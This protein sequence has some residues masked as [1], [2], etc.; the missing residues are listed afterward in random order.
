[1]TILRICLLALCLAYLAQ[2]ATPLR[3]DTDAE[4]LLD[5]AASAADGHGFLHHGTRGHLPL[6][7]PAAIMILDRAGLGAAW[8]FVA[9]NVACVALALACARD[10]YRR[11]FDLP[12][13]QA[14][15]LC[16]LSLLSFPLVK[17]VTLSTSDVPYLGLSMLTLWLLVRAGS[18]SRN[19]RW[20]L[21]AAALAVAAAAI[22]TRTIGI[23]LLLPIAA[24]LVHQK[25]SGR[26]LGLFVSRHRW[27]VGSLALGGMVAAAVI[28]PSAVRIR[29]EIAFAQYAEAGFLPTI[30]NI[31]SHRLTEWGSLA[32]NLPASR[33][34][35]AATFFLPVLGLAVLIVLARGIWLRREKAGVLE[36][37]L[38]AYCAL[39]CLWPSSMNARFWVPM[40][41]L[42]AAWA[43]LALRG[44][45]ASLWWRGLRA[46]YVAGFAT[47]GL[48]A[49]AFST[50]LSFSGAKFSERYGDTTYRNS[51]RAAF[52]REIEP[53]DPPADPAAIRLLQR[54]EPLARTTAAPPRAE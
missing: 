13:V 34:P 35:Q 5:L 28:F 42:L 1:M 49:L 3:L 53:V 44:V 11:A 12:P 36:L 21:L 15:L 7:Y 33:L 2:I 37:Y 40:I 52:G 6:G 19:I 31:L 9:L 32:I 20:I 45:S 39:L 26:A 48:L 16:V 46:S 50:R 14:D 22:A 38:V 25:P 17:H 43:V 18:A 54:Y 29:L 30:A 41:P 8:V 27:L 10:L 23:A 24:A 47:A 51:Y 4:E